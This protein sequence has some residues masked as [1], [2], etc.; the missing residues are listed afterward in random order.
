MDEGRYKQLMRLAV[1][2]TLAW[3]GWSIYD[4]MLKEAA[5]EDREIIAA[6]KMLEDGRFQD[7]QELYTELIQRQPENIGLLRGKAQALMRMGIRDAQEA[8]RQSDAEKTEQLAANAGYHLR[9]ALQTYDEAIDRE[10]SGGVTDLNRRALGVS[11]ANRG[12]LKDQLADYAGALAD[13]EHAMQ[14]EPEVREGPGWLTRFLRNQP[15]KPP[16]VADRAA[17]LREQLA[18]PEAERLLSLPR[19]DLKQRAYKMD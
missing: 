16:S 17:Y 18:R 4:G 13:Y 9:L 11:Y 12:I 6:G 10:E 2:L 14:L 8:S 5:P 19:E 7:A 15:E 1:V 3:V